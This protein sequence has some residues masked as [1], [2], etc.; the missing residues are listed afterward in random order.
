MKG[1]H[2][3]TATRLFFGKVL[4]R[5][6]TCR[7]LSIDHYMLPNTYSQLRDSKAEIHDLKRRNASLQTRMDQ[8]EKFTAQENRLLFDFICEAFFYIIDQHHVMF[9]SQKKSGHQHRQGILVQ[10][11]KLPQGTWFQIV[12]AVTRGNP[13]VQWLWTSHKIIARELQSLRR[14]WRERRIITAPKTRNQL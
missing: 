9:F 3:L 11:M 6:V 4:T 8:I 10:Q 14:P 5:F 1:R 7:F 12:A 2:N 13:T